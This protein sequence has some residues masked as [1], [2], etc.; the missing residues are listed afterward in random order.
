MSQIYTTVQ[1]RLYKQHD[2]DL[3]KY[4]SK[5]LSEEL[6]NSLIALSKGET[7]V[8]NVPKPIV[9]TDDI[10]EQ[11]LLQFLLNTEEDISAI[12]YLKQIPAPKTSQFLKDML[13]NNLE[14][15]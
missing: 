13:R 8:F 9:A 12:E 10:P 6:R 1:L 4:D 14:L 11:V 15:K 3:M 2:M 7:Y 5:I